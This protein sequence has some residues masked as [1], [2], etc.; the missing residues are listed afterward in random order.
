MTFLSQRGHY[1][2]HGQ[3]TLMSSDTQCILVN[4]HINIPTLPTSTRMRTPLVQHTQLQ[5]LFSVYDTK[6]FLAIFLISS[7]KLLTCSIAIMSQ[8]SE[9]MVTTTE[10]RSYQRAFLGLD[11]RSVME[12]SAQYGVSPVLHTYWTLWH[13]VQ[14]IRLYD[15]T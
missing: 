15:V 11:I 14:P 13:L 12:E 6:T 5:K 4:T 7:T 2:E 10:V 1:S 8:I 9:S 3:G